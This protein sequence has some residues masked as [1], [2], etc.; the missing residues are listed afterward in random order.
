MRHLDAHIRWRDLIP[1]DQTVLDGKGSDTTDA[2]VFRNAVICDKK[3][4]ENKTAYAIMFPNQKH[5]PVRM[6]KNI[7]ERENNEDEKV[8]LWFSENHIPLY[9]IKDFEEKIGMK[10]PPCLKVL[11]STCFPKT[12][13]KQIN[14]Y[15]KDIFDYLFHKG[16][17]PSKSPCVSCKHDVLLRSYFFSLCWIF[18]PFY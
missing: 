15:Y 5:L 9:L 2:S 3:M 18:S 17:K 4:I 10:A 12:Q 11:S 8:K 1:P 13:R 16:E 14:A 6:T 7:L